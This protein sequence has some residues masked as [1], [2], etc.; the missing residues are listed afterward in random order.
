MEK[1]RLTPVKL[2]SLGYIIT[3]F[4][5]TILL[6]LPFSKNPGQHTSFIDA[7]FTATSATCVTGLIPFDTLTHWSK[8]GQIIILSLIQIGGLGFMTII[9]L[10]MMIFRRKIGFYNKTVLMQSAGSYNVFEVTRLIK[11]IIVG[12]ILF[13]GLGAFIL[14]KQFEKIMPL[15]DAIYYGI[16]HS[17]S[18]FCNAGFDVFGPNA[19]SLTGFNNNWIV[20]STI[21]GLIV[22]GGLGFIVWSDLIDSK[23]NFKKLQLHSK[24]VLVYNSLFI[25]IPTILYF[26]FEFTGF[27]QSGN[28]V[29]YSFDKKILN[30]MFLSISPRT[31][32]FNSVDLTMLTSGGKLLTIFLMFVGGNPGS[33]AGGIK[34]TTFI[35]IVA[36]LIA[37]SKKNS[38]VVLFKREVS[39]DLIKQ[40]SSLFLAYLMMVFIATLSISMV[41][42]FTLEEILFEVVSAIGTVGLSLG[43]SG[44]CSIFTKVV[45]I[46]L[47]YAGRLGA[48]TL[49]SIFTGQKSKENLLEPKGRMLVG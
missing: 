10:F 2:L 32:G 30:S 39:S 41:D 5:G 35:V 22:I 21:M 23:F 40:S 12:T 6:W 49:F 20:L 17:I 13:E 45:L 11:R 25:L 46:I 44:S 48:L 34:V 19:S 47:M 29:N 28:F 36:N 37:C 14:T 9:S 27:G 24:V 16:F 18:A 42:S 31:A 4:I 43:V 1:K 26:V 38:R 33:T 8:A 3:I 7:L 15:D